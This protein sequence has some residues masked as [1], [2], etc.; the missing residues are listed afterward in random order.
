MKRKTIRHM[1]PISHI[2][3]IRLIFFT[4]LLAISY[5]LLAVILPS[6]H[7]QT[8]PGLDLTISPP[9]MEFNVKPGE[10]IKEK[11][12]IRNNLTNPI[13][14]GLSVSKLSSD[15]VNGEAVPA[16]PTSADEFISWLSLDS[17][18]LSVPSK[19]WKEVSFS[20]DVPTSA[21]Y[22]YYYVLRITPSADPVLNNSGAK[23]KGEVLVV[24][25][26][27]VKKDGALAKGEL[28]EFKPST[29]VSEYLPV[30]FS[31]KIKNQGNVH[32]KPR[33]NVFI[34]SFR[35]KDIA[36][37]DVNFNLAS[38]LPGGTK[39]Y[40]TSWSDGFIV[41]VPVVENDKPKLDN[42]G[43]PVTK[44]QINWDKLT[45]FR[46]GKYT[47]SILMVYDDG[48]RDATME[49]TAVFWLIPY[50]ALTVI[51]VSLIALVLIIRF[52]LKWYIR[53]ELKHQRGR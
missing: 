50:T 17:S 11:F 13:G 9:V 18:K 8:G 36:I 3:H 7:A 41:R 2:R 39:T 19:E 28:V 32:M 26:L 4:V 16:E 14:L 20:I 1:G 29:F 12:R 42:N 15:S 53:R 27:N 25:L 49:S 44:I 48:K 10:T 21:A 5:Y 22:G 43:N 37:L 35:Q 30:D 33:G 52:L 34:R 31:V 45:H 51:T 24:I 6:V 38:V 46:V 47:A 40:T 23:V